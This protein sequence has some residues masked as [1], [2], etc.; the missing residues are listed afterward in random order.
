[1]PSNATR[2]AKWKGRSKRWMEQQPRYSA[3][4][5][6]EI[7]RIVYTPNGMIPTKRD[8][9]G[10][11]LGALDLYKN[12]VVL[13]QVKGGGKPL[14]ALQADAQRA[15]DEYEFPKKAVRL[16]L[17]VWRPFA[18]DPIVVELTK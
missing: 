12:K 13:I 17:H 9:L 4:F 11:D 14:K 18:H 3:V 8:Q 7:N 2:G 5:D 1:M 6:M 16:E 10:A 15:F